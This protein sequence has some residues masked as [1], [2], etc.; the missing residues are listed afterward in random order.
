M[1]SCRSGRARG[2]RKTRSPS[3]CSPRTS[4]SRAKAFRRP[5]G[6]PLAR[7]AIVRRST[8]CS[9]C[10]WQCA[11]A[12]PSRSGDWDRCTAVAAAERL[13]GATLARSNDRLGAWP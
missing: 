4:T 1:S 12:T 7:R 9:G 3:G 6:P 13:A 11:R 10:C 2:R 8:R 5:T